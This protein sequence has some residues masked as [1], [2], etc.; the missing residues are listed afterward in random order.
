MSDVSGSSKPGH[1]TPDTPA[2]EVCPRGDPYGVISEA[3]H[4]SVIRDDR[5]H[6]HHKEL[7]LLTTRPP[8]HDPSIRHDRST[9]FVSSLRRD[10]PAEVRRKRG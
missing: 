10:G 5:H 3:D 6:A 1:P 2:G 8:L 9:T 7:S 4:E